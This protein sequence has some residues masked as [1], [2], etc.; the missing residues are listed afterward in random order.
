MILNLSP[1]A[2]AWGIHDLNKDKLTLRDKLN[3]IKLIP[4]ASAWG[5]KDLYKDKISLRDKLNDIKLIPP[6]VIKQIVN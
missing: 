1:Y 6:P 4:H 3:D 5:I 2:S